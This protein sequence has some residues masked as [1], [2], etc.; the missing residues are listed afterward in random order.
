M[1]WR[2]LIAALGISLALTSFALA[3]DSKIK[4][5]DGTVLV[6]ELKKYGSSY[7]IT[8]PDGSSKMVPV[9]DV[10]EIDGKPT[11]DSATPPTTVTPGV[12]QGS[13]G[14]PGL[15]AIKRNAEKAEQAIV[16]MKIWDDWITA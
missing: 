2:L 4:L 15:D 1:R 5:K 9:G 3:V 12:K 6:G 7:R 11:A 14:S 8:M 16:G 10:V 13:V